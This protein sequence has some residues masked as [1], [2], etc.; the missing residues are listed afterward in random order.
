M[1]EYMCEKSYE[2]ENVKSSID[3]KSKN[4]SKCI[5]WNRFTE[6][7]LNSAIKLT[8]TQFILH[9]HN[10]SLQSSVQWH[11][12]MG[13]KVAQVYSRLTASM[14]CRTAAKRRRTRERENASKMDSSA[15]IV[16]ECNIS[17]MRTKGAIN[18]SVLI[19]RHHHNKYGTHTHHH[20]TM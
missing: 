18:C 19:E 2:N 17:W 3:G 20:R 9:A 6:V 5:Q 15:Q 1:Y 10:D 8:A 12:G 14:Q 11:A 7:R 4:V 13:Y 16:S